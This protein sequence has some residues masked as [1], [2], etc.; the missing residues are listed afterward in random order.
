MIGMRFCLDD[1]CFLCVSIVVLQS[2]N[3]IIC[4]GFIKSP[5]DASIVFFY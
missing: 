1:E 2:S 5:F 4:Q 3:Y